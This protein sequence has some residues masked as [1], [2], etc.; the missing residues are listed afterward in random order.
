MNQLHSTALL[1]TMTKTAYRRKGLIGHMV[2][3]DQSP[4]WWSKGMAARTAKSS[5]LKLQAEIRTAWEWYESFEAPKPTVGD[6]PSL[7]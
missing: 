7:N 1:N 5:Q 6:T 3:E 2:S 4:R